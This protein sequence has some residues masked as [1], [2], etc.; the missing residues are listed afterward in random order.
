MSIVGVGGDIRLLVRGDDIEAI[1]G[2]ER[3]A[4]G[5]GYGGSIVDEDHILQRMTLSVGDECLGQIPR[6][7]SLLELFLPLLSYPRRS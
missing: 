1:A 3:V 5:D 2:V 4:R 6:E 7:G